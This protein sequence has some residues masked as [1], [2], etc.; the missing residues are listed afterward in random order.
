MANYPLSQTSG[1]RLSSSSR[2]GSYSCSYWRSEV[3][4]LESVM[5]IRNDGTGIHASTRR[6]FDC[7]IF[8]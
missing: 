5:D 7:F 1:S 4:N 8:Q 6:R 3:S 2:P